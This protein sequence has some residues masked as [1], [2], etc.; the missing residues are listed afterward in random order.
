MLLILLW[1]LINFYN[2]NVFIE[3][4]FF[5]HEFV[6]SWNYG[7]MRTFN[8]LNLFSLLICNTFHDIDVFSMKIILFAKKAYLLR[9]FI[10]AHNVQKLHKIRCSLCQFFICKKTKLILFFDNS[11]SPYYPVAKPFF[12][13]FFTIKALNSFKKNF[14]RNVSFFA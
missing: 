4:N 9:R 13:P 11:K 3:R 1:K 7:I 6:C 12:S 5:F 8:Y 2:L 10:C 14:S